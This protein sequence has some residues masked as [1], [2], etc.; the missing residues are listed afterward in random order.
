M[1]RLSLKMVVG[2][3]PKVTQQARGTERKLRAS[4]GEA[5]WGPTMSP[6]EGL[7]GT[8]AKALSF[9]VCAVPN[10]RPCAPFLPRPACSDPQA[11]DLHRH[12]ALPLAP[13]GVSIVASFFL[14]VLAG[15]AQ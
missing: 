2:D 11:R 8:G 1:E 9:P 10:V 13:G 14:G 5:G 3:L 12:G 15:G 7:S 4:P 6:P